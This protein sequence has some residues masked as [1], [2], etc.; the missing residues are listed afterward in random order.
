M[1]PHLTIATGALARVDALAA[2]IGEWLP[3]RRRV[4]EAAL[5]IEDTQ[6]RWSVEERFGL[7]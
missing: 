1:I 7:G 2:E 3:V 5:L 4:A 6:G